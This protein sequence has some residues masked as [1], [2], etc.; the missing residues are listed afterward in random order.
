MKVNHISHFIVLLAVLAGGVGVFFYVRPNTTLQ[1]LTGIITAV[2]YVAWGLIHHAIERDL[3]Q[4]V[5]VEY[6]LIG[7]IAIVLLVTVLGF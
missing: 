1:L 3:H 7:A 5:V 2:S 6:I 4:K